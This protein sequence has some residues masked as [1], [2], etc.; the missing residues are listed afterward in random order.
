MIGVSFF[1][2]VHL[3]RVSMGAPALIGYV[4]GGIV[5]VVLSAIVPRFRNRIPPR[6]GDQAAEAYWSDPQI[7][8]LAVLIWV[9][10]EA[11]CIIGLVGYLMTA[12]W[13]P[14]AAAGIAFAN[15]V[16]IAPSRLERR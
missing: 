8:G 7:R 12:D 13:A 15:Y 10:T 5:I 6:H 2:V 1:I 16:L 3:R 14:A 9:L 11:A 4:L